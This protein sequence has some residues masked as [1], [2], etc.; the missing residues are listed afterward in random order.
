MFVGFYDKDGG[1]E[2]K[3]IAV[4]LQNFSSDFYYELIYTFGPFLFN[5]DQL[6]SAIYFLFKFPRYNR[7][8]E[9]EKTTIRYLDYYG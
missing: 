5:L 3:I 8:F 9:M 7:L 6:N 4:I 1:Y 2:P